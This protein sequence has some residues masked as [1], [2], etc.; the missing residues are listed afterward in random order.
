LTCCTNQ[1]LASLV[2]QGVLDGDFLYFYLKTQYARL[3]EI[4]SGDGTRG[5]L[6][7][8]MLRLYRIPLPPIPVQ[9]EIVRILDA[10]DSLVTD[11]SAGLPAEIAARRKQYEYYSDKLLSFE[12]LA[13]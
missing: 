11:L 2:P 3:R 9:F 13:T 1:S 7:L 5:G 10:F 6:N 4:S 8:E 12:K